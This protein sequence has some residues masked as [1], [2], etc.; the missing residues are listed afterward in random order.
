MFATGQEVLSREGA[1]YFALV[2]WKLTVT[3]KEY[4]ASFFFLFK[5]S[6]FRARFNQVSEMWVKHY[7]ILWCSSYYFPF[8][9]PLAAVFPLKGPSQSSGP[10]GSALLVLITCC[11]PDAVSGPLFYVSSWDRAPLSSPG[12]PQTAGLTASASQVLVPQVWQ[13]THFQ[14]S[15]FQTHFLCVWSPIL[16]YKDIAIQC[17]ALK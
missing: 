15:Y 17:F 14:I 5:K 13:C 1:L 10:A 7:F 16:M 9:V 11:P 12:W 3:N 8:I 6:F 4:M 2:L